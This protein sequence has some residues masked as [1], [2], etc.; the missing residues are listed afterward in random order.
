MRAYI[1]PMIDFGYGLECDQMLVMWL[2]EV[3]TLTLEVSGIDSRV[4]WYYDEFVDP[5]EYGVKI[6]I[7][8]MDKARFIFVVDQI[9]DAAMQHC[10][11]VTMRVTA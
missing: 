7:E 11:A 2:E 1:I 8:G 5:I 10:D 6:D 4:E 9:K 3:T